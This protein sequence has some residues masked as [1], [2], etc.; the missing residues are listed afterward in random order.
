MDAVYCN[1]HNPWCDN[2]SE[3][4]GSGWF[5]IAIGNGKPKTFCS[6]AHAILY[7]HDPMKH[8][9][10]DIEPLLDKDGREIS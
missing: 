1:L 8:A 10:H 9:E 6:H 4:L 3:S 5:S 2:W 7:L